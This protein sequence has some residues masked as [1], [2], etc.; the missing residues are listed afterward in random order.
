MKDKIVLDPSLESL[1]SLRSQIREKRKY[2]KEH[3]N[4][5]QT[6]QTINNKIQGCFDKITSII[7]SEIRKI[8]NSIAD[9]ITNNG[10]GNSTIN[11]ELDTGAVAA[12][13]KL[14][15]LKGLSTEEA[16][17]L[18]NNAILKIDEDIYEITGNHHCQDAVG[19]LNSEIIKTISIKDQL[20]E[21]K[22]SIISEEESTEVHKPKSLQQ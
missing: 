18:I 11:S 4:D 22:K 3:I 20:R 5:Q 1:K 16:R 2:I 17:A 7:N 14:N 6:I 8:S 10:E 19:L 13:E 12:I 21:Q 15:A 9:I